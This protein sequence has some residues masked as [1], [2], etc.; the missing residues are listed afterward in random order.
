MTSY[1][2][3]IFTT[4]TIGFDCIPEVNNVLELKIS[5]NNF[6]CCFVVVINRDSRYCLFYT[7]VGLSATIF[8]YIIILIICYETID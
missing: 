3:G 5:K 1:G 6:C 4:V 8:K 7:H 2:L